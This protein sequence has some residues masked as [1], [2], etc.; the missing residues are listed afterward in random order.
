M[1]RDGHSSVVVPRYIIEHVLT[2]YW[3]DPEVE[4]DVE[5]MV[6]LAKLIGFPLPPEFEK[7]HRGPQPPGG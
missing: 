1:K 5:T 7:P 4:A 3:A 6:D 2:C